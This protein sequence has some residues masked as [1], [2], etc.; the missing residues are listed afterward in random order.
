[1]R[2]FPL[3]ALLALA[4]CAAT[5]ADQRRA[6]DAEAVRQ[7]KLANEF[8][9]LVPGEPVS[10]LPL[11]PAQQYRTEVY[12]STIVYVASRTLKYRN[13]T[14]GGCGGVGHR[15]DILIT[16]S[17]TGRLCRGD[18]ARTVDRASRIETGG[19]ALGEF[20]PYRKAS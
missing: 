4:A 16:N 20:T 19:C 14:G 18:L 2:P 17:P 6:A 12:G 10:C 9:G 3:L 11:S 5:P 8:A 7:Q 15:D 1:M 13:E